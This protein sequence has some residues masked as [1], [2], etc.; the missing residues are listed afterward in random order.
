MFIDTYASFVNPGIRIDAFFVHSKQF[1]RLRNIKQ[2]GT[3]Y[4]VWLGAS[5]NRFEHCIGV[6]HLARSMASRLKYIQ[7]ELGIT[8]RDVECV[9]I[10]GLC[11]DLGHGPWSH[12]WDGSFIPKALP[13]TTWKHEDASAM[14]FDAMVRENDIPLDARDNAFIK[15]LIAGDPSQCEPGEKPFLFDIV[16]NKR[17]GLDVDKFDYIP[18]DS[19][20]IG[21]KMNIGSMRI[22]NS[23]RVLDNQICYNL[24]DANLI[25]EICAT[26]FKLHKMIYSHK[27]AKAIEYMIIDALLLAEPVLQIAKQVFDPAKY[28]HLTD[29]IMG[30][31]EASE[32][33]RLA[34]SRAIF[35]RIRTRDLYRMVDF[36]V[37]DWE[38]AEVFRENIT[39]TRVFEAARRELDARDG[40]KEEG[41]PR[42]VL[43]EDDVIIDFLMMHY[44]MK[45]RNPLDFVKFYSKTHPDVPGHAVRGVISNLMPEYH[46]EF[47]LRIYT[48]KVE[49][50]GVIQAGYRACLAVIGKQIKE[51]ANKAEENMEEFEPTPLY[52]VKGKMGASM[53]LEVETET[54]TDTE[55]DARTRSASSIAVPAVTT[56]AAD[57]VPLPHPTT[58]TTRPFSRTTS[59]FSRAGS[60]SRV[61]SFSY[62]P[63]GQ[64]GDDTTPFE[65]NA[66]TTVAPTFVPVSPSRKGRGKRK[67][68]AEQDE[69]EAGRDKEQKMH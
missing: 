65:N 1:Q 45:E 48:K 28:L 59:K 67:R 63:G 57:P 49:F 64:G 23:A 3:C 19:H 44:G 10:A 58:P 61:G 38:W 39:S 31:I 22:V 24:K 30:R 33:P 18:R 15:A 35:D 36:K 14:M 6:A 16:A 69:G 60:F 43:E 55:T 34:P 68:E 26:R 29:D 40:G 7:P 54:E 25:Y 12:V 9:E 32:D 5:H 52:P 46:A 50:F 20:M 47:L 37:V 27:A 17:N 4:Y 11:H 8:E 21:D 53:D 51:A 42:S 62:G 66:F 41:A 56:A 13:G 2:L